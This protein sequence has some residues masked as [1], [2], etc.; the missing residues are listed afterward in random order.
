[1]TAAA[2]PVPE[3]NPI[4]PAVGTTREVQ[5]EILAIE[6]AVTTALGAV[7]EAVRSARVVRLRRDALMDQM[8]TRYR[9][10]SARLPHLGEDARSVASEMASLR[11]SRPS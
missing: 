3:R 6:N 11:V 9:R 1:M 7:G 10:R 4:V 8:G 5:D 2:A